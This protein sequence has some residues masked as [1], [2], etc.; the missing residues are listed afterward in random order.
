LSPSLQGFRAVGLGFLDDAL[1]D[2]AAFVAANVA[3][4]VKNAGMSS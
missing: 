3:A 2:A 1:G 4:V